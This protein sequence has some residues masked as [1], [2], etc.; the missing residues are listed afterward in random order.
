[1]RQVMILGVF[2]DPQ[3]LCIPYTNVQ[4]NPDEDF[5]DTFAGGCFMVNRLEVCREGREAQT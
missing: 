5:A 2:L 4:N 1:M 3:S